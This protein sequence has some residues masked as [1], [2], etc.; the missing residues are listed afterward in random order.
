MKNDVIRSGLMQYIG[1]I[2]SETD[3]KDEEAAHLALAELS[4]VWLECCKGKNG[5]SYDLF[6]AKPVLRAASFLLKQRCLEIERL[7]VANTAI[8]DKLNNYKQ[9][10]KVLDEL[11]ESVKGRTT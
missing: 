6:I 5:K 4:E 9:A 10:S 3:H 8:Q 2:I 7:N 11:V 1:A